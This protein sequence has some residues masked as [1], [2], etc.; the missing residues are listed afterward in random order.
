MWTVR[1][2]FNTLNV[3]DIDMAGFCFV[4]NVC[5]SFSTRSVPQWG[6]VVEINGVGPGGLTSKGW[7][8]YFKFIILKEY[9]V[10]SSFKYKNYSFLKS[11]LQTQ[12]SLPFPLISSLHNSFLATYVHVRFQDNLKFI[13]TFHLHFFCL[14]LPCAKF[15]KIH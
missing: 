13:F 15:H 10:L 11:I 2:Y 14:L 8:K 6:I 1:C 4:S 5:H 3:L 9:K 12:H 7:R